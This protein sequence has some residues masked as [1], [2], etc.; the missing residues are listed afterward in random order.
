MGRLCAT[1]ASAGL[2]GYAATVKGLGAVVLALTIFTPGLL[3]HLSWHVYF[4]FV[5]G[6]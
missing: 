6:T 1:H 4:L 5:P 2:R 3:A